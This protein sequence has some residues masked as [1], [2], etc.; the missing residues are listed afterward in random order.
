MTD[1]EIAYFEHDA[2]PGQRY[3][4]CPK[5]GTSLSVQ[6]CSTRWANSQG[7]GDA[8]VC[9][10]CP[11]GAHH[12][13]GEHKAEPMI[14]ARK[15]CSRCRRV[16]T[17]LIGGVICVSCYNRQRELDIGRNGKGLPPIKHP[18]VAPLR[19]TVRLEG[20][21]RSICT[22]PATGATEGAI[23]CLHRMSG[24]GQVGFSGRLRFG[25]IQESLF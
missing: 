10:R 18:A 23:A 13:G 9:T 1:I 14:E 22:G 4:A 11:V 17:R 24:A 12:A 6:S 15:V 5:T 8:G 3:F 21:T 19:V 20:L 16:S 7:R 2:L 25:W